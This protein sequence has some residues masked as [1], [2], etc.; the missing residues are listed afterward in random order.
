MG[1][2]KKLIFHHLLYLISKVFKNSKLKKAITSNKETIIS[3][4]LKKPNNALNNLL[5][6][7]HCKYQLLYEMTSSNIANAIIII[8]N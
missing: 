7:F 5:H 4:I 8:K 3:K 6:L 2:T 1:F